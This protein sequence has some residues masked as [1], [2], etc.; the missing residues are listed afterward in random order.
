[1]TTP[2]LA[3][4]HRCSGCA[5][6]LNACRQDAMRFELDREGFYSPIVDSEKCVGCRLCEKCCPILFPV[7][8]ERFDQPRAYACWTQDASARVESSSGGIFSV[9]AR[10]ILEQGGVVFGVAFDS[11]QCARFVAVE[12]EEELKTLRSSKYVQAEVGTIYRRAQEELAKGRVALFAGTPCQI[13]GLNAFLGKKYDRLY[14]L[15]LVCHGVP[16]PTL[17]RKWLDSIKARDRSEIT[18][19]SHRAKDRGWTSLSTRICR[20]NGSVESFSWQDKEADYFGEFFLSNASLRASCGSCPFATLPRQGDLTVGDF[21]GLARELPF[22]RQEELEKGVSLCLINSER[23]ERLF[24][25]CQERDDSVWIER[26]LQ[27]ALKG[28]PQLSAPSVLHRARAKFIEDSVA[29]SYAEL[30]E[31]Y[32]GKLGPTFWERL[33][34]RIARRFWKIAGKGARKACDKFLAKIKG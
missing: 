30:R 8:I 33:R 13:A 4:F 34:T 32:A 31:K 26:P 23:G 9:L 19:M 28:N 2:T 17:F 27:E 29:L 16:S 1:M 24:K 12:T 6:C 5:A 21:W 18:T 25:R 7:E 3:P 22:E 20:K 10:A 11:E 14:L 15:D